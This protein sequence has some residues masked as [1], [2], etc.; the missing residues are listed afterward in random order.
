MTMYRIQNVF[1]SENMLLKLFPNDVVRHI[2]QVFN[3]KTQ[4][5]NLK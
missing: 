1:G 3:K 5:E 4:L 2:Y